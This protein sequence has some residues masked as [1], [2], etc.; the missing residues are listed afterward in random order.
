MKKRYKSH[1]AVLRTLNSRKQFKQNRRLKSH[2]VSVLSFDLYFFINEFFFDKLI[3]KKKQKKAF[4]L[5]RKSKIV[6]EQC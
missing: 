3:F 5:T 4:Y 1:K 2:L 6:Q